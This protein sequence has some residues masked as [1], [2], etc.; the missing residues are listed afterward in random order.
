MLSLQQSSCLCLHRT[1]IEL[2]ILPGLLT[3]SKDGPD[4]PRRESV[5][6]HEAYKL[7]SI[8]CRPEAQQ[9]SISKLCFIF[10]NLARA[11]FDA[12]A[13]FLAR[14]AS[15][16][17]WNPNVQNV[18]DGLYQFIISHDSFPEDIKSIA[19]ASLAV[20][21]ESEQFDPALSF[22]VIEKISRCI[23]YD[24]KPRGRDLRNA[25]LR[26]Q[27]NLFTLGNSKI[28]TQATAQEQSDLSLWIAM[29]E[30]AAWDEI[31]SLSSL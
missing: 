2:F 19:M 30:D 26:L 9:P 29:L 10:L 15:Q 12:A 13:R 16:E 4:L 22:L 20:S 24:V 14:I 1:I 28:F 8:A 7:L 31:V 6:L 23:L 3:H 11:D 18:I 21:I 5:A 27:A 25:E 17:A